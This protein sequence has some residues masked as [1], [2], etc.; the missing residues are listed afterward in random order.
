MISSARPCV[1]VGL[2]VVI[3]AIDKGDDVGVLLDTARFAKVGHQ[4]LWRIAGLRCTRELRQ[5]E[6]RNIQFLCQA[7]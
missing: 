2:L 7:F 5:S 3:F 4:R 6:D 1:F